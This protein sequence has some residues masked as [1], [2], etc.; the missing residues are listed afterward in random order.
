MQFF[1]LYKKETFFFLK[2]TLFSLCTYLKILTIITFVET[3]KKYKGQLRPLTLLHTRA[4][5][6]TIMRPG[7]RPLSCKCAVNNVCVKGGRCFS[8]YSF[9][10]RVAQYLHLISLRNLAKTWYGIKR[11]CKYQELTPQRMS[12][13]SNSSSAFWTQTV[14]PISILCCNNLQ[15]TTVFYNLLEKVKVEYSQDSQDSRSASTAKQNGHRC[16]PNWYHQRIVLLCRQTDVKKK[17]KKSHSRHSRFQQI[18]LSN[19]KKSFGNC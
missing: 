2:I 1:P 15:T 14:S 18:T 9:S 3:F 12:N 6:Y 7:R 10:A 17:K 5:S 8:P 16:V 13:M 19:A 4:H 11:L